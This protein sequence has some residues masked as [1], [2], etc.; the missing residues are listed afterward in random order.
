MFFAKVPNLIVKLGSSSSIKNLINYGDGSF[1]SF[2][3]KLMDM[4]T[5]KASFN[6]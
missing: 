5:F 2:S 4:V 6:N 3:F 1:F